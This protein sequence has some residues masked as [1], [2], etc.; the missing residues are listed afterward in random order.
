MKIFQKLLLLLFL[1]MIII[2]L[3]F[4]RIDI[5]TKKINNDYSTIYTNESYKDAY[6]IKNVAIVKQEISCG[7]A[8]IEMFAKSIGNNE[9]TEKSLYDKYKKVV[10]STGKSFEKE[11]NILFPNYNTTMYKYLSNTTLIDK[12][13][14]SLKNNIPVPFEWAAKLNNE[15]TLHY[16]LIIGIDVFNDQVIIL[17]PYGYEEI[18]SIKELLERT[19]Y[20]SYENMPIFLKFGFAFNLFEKNTIFI[21]EKKQ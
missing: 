4:I 2:I 15:W 19:S 20:K 21:A 7:Y 17:N 1:L 8:T 11:M 14:N 5:K 9:I 12:V 16:S 10:T 13:Y 18:I 3:L 6:I